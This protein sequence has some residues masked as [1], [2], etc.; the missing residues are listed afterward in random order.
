MSELI[1]EYALQVKAQLK[2]LDVRLLAALSALGLGAT[3]ICVGITYIS[4][5]ESTT[6][7]TSQRQKNAFHEPARAPM[8]IELGNV[9]INSILLVLQLLFHR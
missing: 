6:K 7:T 8:P 2:A 4:I 9:G 3:F 5:R 1:E